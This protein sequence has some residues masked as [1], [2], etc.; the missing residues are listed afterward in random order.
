MQITNVLAGLA[1][2]NVDEAKRWYEVFFG[3]PADAEPMAGLAEWRTPGGVLQLV[4][5]E[6]RAGGSLVTVWVADARGALAELA[7][8]GGPEVKLDDT[9]SDKV[10]FATACDPDGNAVTVVEVREGVTL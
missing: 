10:L 8:R 7:T 1:V 6:Q 3:R 2:R 4:H 5:D 9:T